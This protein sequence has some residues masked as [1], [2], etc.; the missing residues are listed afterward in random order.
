MGVAP[1]APLIG[2]IG[3]IVPWKGQHIF[4]DALA[5]L[6][7]QHPEVIAVIVGE[8]HGAQEES[9]RQK[10]LAQARALDL[11]E[12]LIWL[13]YRQDIPHILAGL[14]MLIHCSVKPEP[15]GRVII[16]GMAAGLPVIASDAGGA[17]E[18]VEDG[19]NGLLTPP[20]DVPAL[21]AA[22]Q[23]ILEDRALR[24]RLQSAGR[25][26][27]REHYSLDAHVA[28]VTSFYEELLRK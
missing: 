7:Q 23:K 15:F 14:G 27:A 17:K 26:R 28:A 21:A 1:D 5:R 10:L 8:A 6:R 12:N 20:G 25:Q 22:M 4:L 13:G 2:M 11:E 3:R 16:E 9:Y 18:I 19:V 24:E